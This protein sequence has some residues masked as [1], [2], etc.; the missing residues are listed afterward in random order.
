MFAKFIYYID[1]LN[2]KIGEAISW[3]ALLMA[4]VQVFILGLL[5]FFNIG[6]LQLQESILY[7]NGTL[8]ML[9][10]GW[11]FKHDKHVRVDLFYRALTKR[12]QAKTNLA[13]I[14]LFLLPLCAVMLWTSTP[15]TLQG[16]R[17]LEGSRET[18]GI[19]A[20]FLLKTI[21]PLTALLL[22]LQA[23][24]EA[25]KAFSILKKK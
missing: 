10:M 17:I 1:Q 25:A 20:L 3:L 21:I 9:A 23:F 2:E 19:P 12:E 13:G 11:T 7:M 4:F 15:Y 6:S 5:Y 14:C 18:G 16:W 8:F 24:A 22:G